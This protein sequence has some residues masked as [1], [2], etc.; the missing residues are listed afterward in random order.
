[1]NKT[2]SILTV[3]LAVIAFNSA[4]VLRAAQ[5][6]SVD[7]ISGRWVDDSDQVDIKQSG[8]LVTGEI[9]VN[10]SSFTGTRDGDVITF[11]LIYR[12]DARRGG[13]RKSEGELKLNSDGTILTG[14][15]SGGAF[16][17]DSKWVLTRETE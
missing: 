3:A 9:G 16:R 15:R 8:D 14:T 6:A 4:N 2:K 7:D 5:A 11:T 17:K 1:M 10:G 12:H 13:G